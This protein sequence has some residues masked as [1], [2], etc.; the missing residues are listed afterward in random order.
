M[1]ELHHRQI[2][3]VDLQQR[4]IGARV[5]TDHGRDELAS[6]VHAHD[7][8]VRV[9]DDVV[10]GEDVALGGNDESRTERTALTERCAAAATVGSLR[11][12][13]FRPEETAEELVHVGVAAAVAATVGS[14]AWC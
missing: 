14:F 1:A 10:V 13:P 6:I 8:L 4:Q 11:A 12:A 5:G 7:D 9:F 2:G 3:R